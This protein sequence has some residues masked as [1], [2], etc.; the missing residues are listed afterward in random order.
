MADRDAPWIR[1]YERLCPDDPIHDE[2]PRRPAIAD[3]MRDLRRATTLAEG[4]DVIGWWDH[5]P[6]TDAR[7]AFVRR[8]MRALRRSKRLAAAYEREVLDGG[9]NG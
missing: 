8:A 6:S 9:V 2:D 7:D 3:E 1:A 4:L 5:W